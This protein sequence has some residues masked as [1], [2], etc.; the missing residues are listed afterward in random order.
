M[1]GVGGG[2][3]IHCEGGRASRQEHGKATEPPTLEVFKTE[4][5]K[6]LSNTITIRTWCW[7]C[8]E[9][10][11]G[12]ETSWDPF[13]PEWL[14]NSLFWCDKNELL[15]NTGW[16]NNLLTSYKGTNIYTLK[17]AKKLFKRSR[18]YC[19]SCLYCKILNAEE[20]SGHGKKKL[21]N[22]RYACVRDKLLL[23]KDTKWKCIFTLASLKGLQ[24]GFACA[25]KGTQSWSKIN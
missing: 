23:V 2:R 13:Q 3:N 1:I 5:D 18:I 12:L 16:K 6:A 24:I 19:F 22:K 15:Q 25:G 8:F 21:I 7:P 20:L 17:K 9:Q 4:L 14:C 11:G 10:E